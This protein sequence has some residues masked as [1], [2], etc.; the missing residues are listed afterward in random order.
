MD[1]TGKTLIAV[2]VGFGI[3]VGVE[4]TKLV[5]DRIIIP[6]KIKL[7]EKKIREEES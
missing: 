2:C 7:L 6:N 5:Y 4:F 1:N 3:M